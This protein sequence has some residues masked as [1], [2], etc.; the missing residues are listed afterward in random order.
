MQISPNAH[1]QA[2]SLNTMKEVEKSINLQDAN[3][4]TNLT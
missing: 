4:K 3:L 1:V 2:F